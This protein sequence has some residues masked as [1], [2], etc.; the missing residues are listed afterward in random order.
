MVSLW[1]SSR[2]SPWNSNNKAPGVRFPDSEKNSSLYISTCHG[3]AVSCGEKGPRQNVSPTVL[4][5]IP[6]AQCFQNRDA[7]Y[8]EADDS[9]KRGD[10]QEICAEMKEIG[11][12]RANRAD[13]PQKIEPERRMD[14]CAEVL[15]QVQLQ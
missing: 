15:T 12:H 14:A 4:L 10:Q 3:G 11:D 13:E 5:E 1:S 6:F 9:S 8:G 2:G 7:A